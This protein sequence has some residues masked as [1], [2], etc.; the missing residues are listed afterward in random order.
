MV[1][2]VETILGQIV[3]KA[4]NYQAVRDKNGGRRIIKNA[5][6]RSYENSFIRQ[7][8]IYKNRQIHTPFTLQAT[9]Y[10]DNNRCDLDNS[11]KTLL[12]CLQYVGAITDDKLCTRIEVSKRIGKPRVEFALI[13]EPEPP[14]LFNTVA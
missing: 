5:R 11:I 14:N 2:E 12:D 13:A 6:I 10:Y 1:A 8:T 3:G 9:M 7:C 4:N